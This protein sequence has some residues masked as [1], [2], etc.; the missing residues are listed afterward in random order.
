ME[1]EKIRD[2]FSS[3]LEKELN[4]SE[5]KSIREHLSSCSECQKDYER[6]EKTIHWLHSVGEVEAPEGFLSGIYKKMADKRSK[7]LIDKKVMSRGF[8]FPASFKIPIQA[9]A[10]VTVIFLVLYITKMMPVETPLLKEEGQIK[11]PL[12]GE[13]ERKGVEV[14][15]GT[16]KVKIAAKPS[17]EASHV[18]EIKPAKAPVPI[19]EK[20][21]ESL[22]SKEKEE[23]RQGTP[24]PPKNMMMPVEAPR[25]KDVEMAKGS[26]PRAAKPPQEIVLRISDR[27]KVLLQLNELVKQF[28][29]E[30]VKTEGN[31]IFASLPV[32]S[33]SAFEKEVIGLSL[34]AKEGK[35]AP[36][37]D[38]M[39]SLRVAPGARRRELQE[40]GGELARSTA[41]KESNIVI[42]ILL[43]QE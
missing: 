2:R 39:K 38:D 22:I 26:A 13:K 1:C 3:L 6:F 14:P 30:I 21:G 29:G 24:P 34:P 9:M 36:E 37:R 15:K 32:A 5:E 20:A 11:A 8:H 35:M 17:F 28:R 18:K 16:E 23:V 12:S 19:E 43:L 42:R 10:M 31:T 33:S 7:V 41:D 4:P 25:L 27:E 40:K